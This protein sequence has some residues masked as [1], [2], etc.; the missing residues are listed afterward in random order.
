MLDNGYFMLETAEG[1][2]D[3]FIILSVRQ[4]LFHVKK[5]LKASE[6]NRFYKDIA[7][8]IPDDPEED[9]E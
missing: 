5:F 3:F 6:I 1:E 2:E 8:E 4:S 7:D 9:D